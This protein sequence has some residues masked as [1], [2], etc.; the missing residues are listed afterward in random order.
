MVENSNNFLFSLPSFLYVADSYWAQF[1]G[2]PA[3]W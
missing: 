2:L 1:L 3:V